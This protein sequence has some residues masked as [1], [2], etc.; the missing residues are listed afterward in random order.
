VRFA[1]LTAFPSSSRFDG[2]GTDRR[3]W[4]RIEPAALELN[5]RLARPHFAKLEAI[6]MGK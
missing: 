6:G 3:R 5:I 4:L 1:F 2:S